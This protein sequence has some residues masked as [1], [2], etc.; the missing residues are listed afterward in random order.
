MATQNWTLLETRVNLHVFS[1]TKRVHFLDTTLELPCVTMPLTSETKHLWL[2]GRREE[3][4]CKNCNKRL[5]KQD[6]TE[7]VIEY[8]QEAYYA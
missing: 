8:T 4:T 1:A 6:I 7:D 2:S 3:V 5:A